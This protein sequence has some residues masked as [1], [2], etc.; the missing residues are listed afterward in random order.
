VIGVPGVSW[1]LRPSDSALF[2]LVRIQRR[3]D[4]TVEPKLEA[5]V[6][7]VVGSL[8]RCPVPLVR[9]H[10]DRESS[11]RSAVFLFICGSR[12]PVKPVPSS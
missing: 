9:E 11:S 12:T 4:V 10:E 8:A 6:V 7:E 2:L 3:E 1:T 5:G